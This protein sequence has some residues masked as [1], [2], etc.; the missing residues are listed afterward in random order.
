MWSIT[1]GSNAYAVMRAYACGFPAVNAPASAPPRPLRTGSK[2]RS[3]TIQAAFPNHVWA[4]DFAFDQ[5]ADAR[6]LKVLTITDEFTKQALAIEVEQL[7]TGDDLV[8]ILD[9]L[10]STHG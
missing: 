8:R 2:Q 1:S 7:I 3:R 10:I 4:L 9:R 5:T 6:V